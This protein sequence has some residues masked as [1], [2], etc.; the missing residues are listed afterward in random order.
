MKEKKV[1]IKQ[2]KWHFDEQ[3]RKVKIIKSNGWQIQLDN[4]IP[5]QLK[6]HGILLLLTIILIVV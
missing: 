2:L 1:T 5:K 4:E 3:D 6:E